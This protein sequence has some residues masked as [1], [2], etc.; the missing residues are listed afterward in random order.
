M[1]CC[2]CVSPCMHAWSV[3][4]GMTCMNNHDGIAWMICQHW[5]DM[6]VAGGGTGLA[7]APECVAAAHG[8][9]IPAREPAH[10]HAVSQRWVSLH[11]RHGCCPC[12]EQALLEHCK[13]AKEKIRERCAFGEDDIEWQFHRQQRVACC[14]WALLCIAIAHAD[15]AVPLHAEFC[16][17]SY[18]GNKSC[19][20]KHPGLDVSRV[21]QWVICS[22]CAVQLCE[23]DIMG[24]VQQV[25]IDAILQFWWQP[26]S[27][28]WCCIQKSVQ[29]AKP[30]S[31][32]VMV[33][34]AG[35]CGHGCFAIERNSHGECN[36]VQEGSTT[37]F[38]LINQLQTSSWK[39]II[40]GRLPQIRT[41]FQKVGQWLQRRFIQIIQIC[42]WWYRS[43]TCQ[44]IYYTT[45]YYILLYTI[46]SRQLTLLQ[47]T[48]NSTD[49]N[50]RC[51][52]SDIQAYGKWS[53]TYRKPGMIWIN[54]WSNLL[55]HYL[56]HWL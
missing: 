14:S 39:G 40:L 54:H 2:K 46:S 38:D 13:Q 23:Y 16:P 47:S 31:L 42:T 33:A 29:T 22:C 50:D 21:C 53:I 56:Y 9:L 28:I 3:N 8:S 6:H 55:N 10:Q 5:H 15:F 20:E 49:S 41:A 35:C 36:I 19:Q 7:H 18:A 1:A 43:C 4:I 24:F 25:D 45:L 30:S 27:S 51:I 12:A 44:C 26:K 34:S 52:C 11:L 37:E 48:W 32:S 17:G